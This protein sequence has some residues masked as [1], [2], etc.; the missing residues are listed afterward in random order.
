MNP[1]N[2]EKMDP[3]ENK[4]NKALKEYK[5]LLVLKAHQGFRDRQA[6]KVQQGREGRED[7]GVYKA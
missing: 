7:K 2:K 5:V 4:G 1:V 6:Y 3:K